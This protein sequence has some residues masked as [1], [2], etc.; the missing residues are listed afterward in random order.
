M[1]YK[2]NFYGLLGLASTIAKHGFAAGEQASNLGRNSCHYVRK[3]VEIDIAVVGKVFER[4]E[5]TFESIENFDKSAKEWFE[6]KE[7]SYNKKFQ[8][9]KIEED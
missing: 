6:E 8:E 2:T 5:N 4:L 7:T 9:A 3:V 1:N